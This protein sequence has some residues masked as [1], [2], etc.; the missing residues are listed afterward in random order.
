MPSTTRDR[1]SRA[2]SPLPKWLALVALVA[3]ALSVAAY[4]SAG[5]VAADPWHDPL[6]AALEDA[7]RLEVIAFDETLDGQRLLRVDDPDAI[8]E[9]VDRI[10]V[11]P[12]GGMTCRCPGDFALVFTGGDERVVLTLHHMEHLRLSTGGWPS[13]GFVTPRSLAAITDWLAEHGAERLDL[14]RLRADRPDIEPTRAWHRILRHWPAAGRSRVAAIDSDT[15]S[16]AAGAAA[17]A[18]ALAD[19]MGGAAAMAAAAMRAL[20]RSSRRLWRREALEA[21]AWA[22]FSIV[23]GPTFEAAL[24]A[25]ADEP[26]AL[27]GAARVAFGSDILFRLPPASRD[28][29]MAAMA[30]AVQQRG[31]AG[32][33]RTLASTLR[34][35]GGPL[36]RAFAE[37]LPR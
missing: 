22:V 1:S 31:R 27:V 21:P 34:S 7:S 9:L 16:T 18:K 11:E 37:A 3:I 5:R 23:D 29:W 24:D 4:D 17:F 36:S 32:D 19:D 2:A 26:L 8:A 20:G 35:E 10:R 15:L 13:D 25:V 6:R 33:L 14:L 30:A 12:M 28:R